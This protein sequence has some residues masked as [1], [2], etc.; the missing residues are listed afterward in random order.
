MRVSVLLFLT[1]PALLLAA[2][3]DSTNRKVPEHKAIRVTNPIKLDGVLSETDWQGPAI[4]GFTQKDPKEGEPASE[5]TKVWFAYDDEA[6][7]VGSRMYWSDP[8]GIRALV[9]RRDQ[10]GNSERIIIS[11]DTYLDR[12]TAYTFAVTASGTRADYYHASDEEFNRDYSF[13]PVWEAKTNIDSLGWTAEM[14]IPL[15]QLRFNAKEVHT[16][17][18]NINRWIPTKNEDDYFVYIPKKETGWSSRFARLNGITGIKPSR[19]LE[20][21]PYGASDATFTNGRDKNNPFDDGVNLKGRGGADVKMGLGPNLTLDATVNP[22]FGQVEADPARV[23][24]SAFEIFFD[25]KRPFFIEGNQLLQGTGPLLYYSRRIGAPPRGRAFGDFVNQPNTSTIL[26]AAKLTGRLASGLSIGALTALTDQEFAEIHDTATASSSEKQVAPRTGFGVLRLQQ[27]FGPSASTVGLSLTGVGRDLSSSRELYSLL[28]RQAYTGR[29]DWNLR[30]K[31]GQYVLSGKLGFSNILGDSFAIQ[32]VQTSS[33]HYFQ[34]PDADHVEFVPGRTSLFGYN[35][36]ISFSKNSGKHWLWELSGGAESPGLE[37]ND[38]GAL[39]TAD[40]IDIFGALRYRETQPGKYFQNYN[41]AFY[42][43]RGWNFGGIHQYSFLDFENN[44][45]F[46][47]FWSAFLGWEIYPRGFSDNFTR[48]GPLMQ[49]ALGWSTQAQLSSNFA[50]NTNWYVYGNYSK[51][52]IGHWYYYLEGKLGLRTSGRWEFSVLPYYER[53]VTARQYQTK[54]AGGRPETYG[55]R[56]VFAFMDQS[57]L[58]TQFR[59]NYA[60][61]PDLTLELYGEP[62]AASGKFY[63]FGELEAAKSRNLRQYGTDGTTVT[64]NSDGSYTVNDTKDTVG[65]S[66]D[67]P[68]PDFNILSFRSNVVL[69]WEWLRGS[70]LFFVWARNLSEFEPQGQLVRPTRLWD[71]FTA[72]GDIFVALKISYWIPV[73]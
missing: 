55:S 2:E 24:L 26:G 29:T 62:F 44:F 50:S 3:P 67:I 5:S 51:N 53:G 58:A 9:S 52:E 7:Y 25:E 23:N 22:D 61:T 30:F 14:R 63:N 13:D 27:E 71:A 6:L 34:R 60:F 17:G 66:F 11:L 12:R 40:D 48:G 70:T 15:S 59:I 56:Y 36:A 72:G 1:S 38:L 37:L 33:A 45:T 39:S 10:T 57:T 28:P 68:N 21:I 35:S 65:G 69:R 49:T 54:L 43:G 20:V 16:W 8:K 64:R 42:T 32:R 19:R 18:F 4:S 47:N 41:L 31:G 73:S 46:K